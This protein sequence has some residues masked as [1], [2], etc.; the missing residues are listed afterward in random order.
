MSYTKITFSG[1]FDIADTLMS[2]LVSNDI[3]PTQI[4]G[5]A[6]IS[7]FIGEDNTHKYEIT[8]RANDVEKLGKDLRTYIQKNYPSIAIDDVAE[9]EEPKASGFGRP[10]ATDVAPTEEAVQQ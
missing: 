4:Y 3:F 10:T 1:V 8:Y 2:D 7:Q 9:V 6:E 5:V